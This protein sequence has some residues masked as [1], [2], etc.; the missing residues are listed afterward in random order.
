M[1]ELELVKRQLK[2]VVKSLCTD[3]PRQNFDNSKELNSFIQKRVA[4][5]RRV[6]TPQVDV[7]RFSFSISTNRDLIPLG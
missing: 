3:F 6:N 1:E 7:L 2:A 4:K 5:L